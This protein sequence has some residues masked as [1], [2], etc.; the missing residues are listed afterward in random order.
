MQQHRYH[1]DASLQLHMCHP[2]HP[3]CKRTWVDMMGGT[4]GRHNG[5]HFS[6][7]PSK[8]PSRHVQQVNTLHKE[9]FVPGSVAAAASA[10]AKDCNGAQ[11]VAPLHP[12][13]NPAASVVH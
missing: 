3:K 8:L 1:P 11:W 2:K 12:L 13:P 10:E 6:P 5:W 4:W 7:T 9:Y